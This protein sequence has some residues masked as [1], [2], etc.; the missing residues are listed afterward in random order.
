M[1]FEFT[2][3]AKG[4]ENIIGSHK[5]T[6]EITKEE[7]LT[8]AGD[9]ILGICADQSMVDFPKIFKENLKTSKKIVVEIEV[10]G[11]KEI[12]TGKGNPNLT[13]THEKDIVIRKSDFLCSRTLMIN[14][15]KASKDINREI[16]EKLKKGADLKFKIILE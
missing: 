13:Y 6:L 4:H 1:T 8:C 12:I 10:E 15:D 11:L 2:I 16:I 5:S 14:S 3:F 7:H 9:C